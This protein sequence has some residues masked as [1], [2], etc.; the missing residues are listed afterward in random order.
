[1]SALLKKRQAQAIVCRTEK[2]YQFFRYFIEKSG[3][4]LRNL[5]HIYQTG[6][7]F[8]QNSELEKLCILRKWPEEIWG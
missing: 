5:F 1:M 2:P 3:L 7:I 6:I 8:P 4:F